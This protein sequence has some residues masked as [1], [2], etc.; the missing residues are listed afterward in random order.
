MLKIRSQ[1][2]IA[3]ILILTTSCTLY[4]NGLR[5]NLPQWYITPQTNDNINLYGV[6]EGF[7]IAEAKNS[8]LNN[9]ASKLKITISSQSSAN[10]ESNQFAASE[11]FRQ[12]IDETIDKITFSDY[13]ITNSAQKGDKIYVEIAVDRNLFISQNVEKLATLNNNMSYIYKNLDQQNIL[14]QRNSLDKITDLA[15][16]AES[17]IY[18]LGAL[19]AINDTTKDSNL[20]KYNSY[21]QDYD[22]ILE[23]IEFFIE[24]KDTPKSITDVLINALNKEKLKIAGSKNKPNNNLVIITVTTDIT[25]QNIYNSN[26]AKLKINFA[27]SSG[28]NQIALSSGQNQILVSNAVEVSGSSVISTDMAIKAAAARLKELIESKG[29][30]KILGINN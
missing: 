26:I 12:K 7:T 30:L 15:D 4:Q 27:L 14:A 9:L 25:A 8:A 5:Y 29:I 20:T 19:E 24:A 2:R 10:L 21:R 16:E 13:K 6:G 22:R 3:L 11:E 1:F 18:I 17:I 28:Q 23:K